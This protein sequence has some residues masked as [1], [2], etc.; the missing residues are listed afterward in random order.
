MSLHG[1]SNGIEF[2]RKKTAKIL[3]KY[4]LT[5][6]LNRKDFFS[7][8]RNSKIHFPVDGVK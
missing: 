6:K 5:N 3:S 7:E 8:I 2:H 1:Y 4:L